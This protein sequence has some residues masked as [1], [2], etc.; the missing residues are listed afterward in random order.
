MTRREVKTFLEEASPNLR[1]RTHSGVRE[2]PRSSCLV[3][4]ARVGGGEPTIQ[5][6]GALVHIRCAV[7]RRRLVR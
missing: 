4:G 1:F 2:E 7:Y 6:H 3:C 5:I